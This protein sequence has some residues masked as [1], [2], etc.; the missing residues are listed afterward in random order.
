VTGNHNCL[1]CRA[2]SVATL[3]DFGPQ[4]PSN[5]FE[6]RDAPPAET[7][8]LVVGQC[9]ACGLFQLINPMPPATAKSRFEWV[10]YNEP[11][12]HLDDL[13]ERLRRLPGI[14]S[15]SR[16]VGLT[17]KDH[18]TLARFNKLGYANTYRID[19][20][21][22]LGLHDACAGLESIQASIDV[23]TASRL[24]ARHG[25]ADL[26]LVRHVLEHA[27][28]PEAFLNSV[29]T[30]VKPGGYLL[31]EMPDCTKFIKACDYS[32]IWEE[33]ITY[34]CISTL[35]S[36]VSVAGL[37]MQETIVYPYPLEDSLIGVVKN[38]SPDSAGKS[39]HTMLP[40]L[41]A[42]GE[43]FS[44][45]YP[46]IRARLQSLLGAWRKTGKRVAIF[47][48]GHLAA[49]FANMYSLNELVDC[50]IDDNPNKQHLLMPGSRLPIYG[51]A[52]LESRAIDFCL[53]SLNPESEQKVLAKNQP[54]L[55]RGGRFMSIFAISPN[56]VYNASAA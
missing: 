36:F 54:F 24:V 46:E 45:R 21:A 25:L 1:C 9:T 42:D 17:Y 44:R 49:K 5:R 22:D 33:H 55:E 38:A 29:K 50:I 43:V 40:T 35:A 27:H 19:M 12:D 39:T 13:V 3:V 18:S 15:A 6:R 32:F 41:I 34:F 2:A 16:I 23:A 31:F 56:A 20:G 4:P 7:H 14:G 11:E 10:T 26:L 52:A 48:A 51:S 47:G 8:P 28:D 37:A 30:L 53:L